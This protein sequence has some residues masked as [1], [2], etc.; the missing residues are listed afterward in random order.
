MLKDILL[1]R[2]EGIY[3]RPVAIEQL[4]APELRKVVILYFF[5]FLELIT[6][7]RRVRTVFQTARVGFP[8]TLTVVAL[9]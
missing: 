7:T 6:I 4:R 9:T 5:F 1:I 8:T 3:L 2:L